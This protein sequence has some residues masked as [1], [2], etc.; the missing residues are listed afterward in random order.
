[1]TTTTAFWR[2]HRPLA[3]WPG[4]EIGIAVALFIMGL[5]AGA[6]ARAAAG[7]WPHSDRAVLAP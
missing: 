1:M 3:G 2:I 6:A 4:I 5:P 7:L